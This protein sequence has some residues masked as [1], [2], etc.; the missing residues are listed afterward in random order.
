METFRFSIV[1]STRLCDVSDAK[2]QGK[3]PAP[4]LQKLLN[5]KK[6]LRLN[7]VLMIRRCGRPVNWQIRE[8]LN[9]LLGRRMIKFQPLTV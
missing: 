3:S 5:P 6:P 9:P 4:E 7:S 1:A 2:L 8:N